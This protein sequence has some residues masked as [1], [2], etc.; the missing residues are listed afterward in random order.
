MTNADSR[1]VRVVAG[2]PIIVEGPVTIELPDGRVVAS[3]R[4]KVAICVC[5]RAKTYPLCDTSHR[6]PA[7]R[8]SAQ[9]TQE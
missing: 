9:R 1:A 2:G 3:D 8:K 6:R 5:R 7:V 4:F